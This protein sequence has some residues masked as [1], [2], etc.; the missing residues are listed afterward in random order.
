MPTGW[1]DEHEQYVATYVLNHMKETPCDSARFLMRHFK[2]QFD[3]SDLIFQVSLSC[4]HFCT[5]T[6]ARVFR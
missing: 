2:Y 5:L 3:I 6:C 1:T 4:C